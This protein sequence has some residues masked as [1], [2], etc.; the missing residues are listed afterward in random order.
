[1]IGSKDWQLDHLAMSRI[2]RGWGG[3]EGSL[4][5]DKRG[6]GVNFFVSVRLIVR[7]VALNFVG[8]SDH[9][10]LTLSIANRSTNSS[11]CKGC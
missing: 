7:S 3:V 9:D 8:N 2:V 6:E 1:M 10:T 4:I 11:Q 5:D